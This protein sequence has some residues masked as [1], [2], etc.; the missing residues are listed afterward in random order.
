MMAIHEAP[1]S[2]DEDARG[3]RVDRRAMAATVVAAI[4]LTAVVSYFG[5]KAAR[6]EVRW[7]DVGYTIESPTEA[8]STFDVYLYTDS[9]ATCRV[10]ALNSRFSE[11]GYTDVAVARSAGRQQRMT[12]TVVTV[13][14]AVTAV[15][16]YCQST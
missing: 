9:D 7:G 4:V 14:P 1:E 8:T 3:R 12:A 13:E 10:R 15:V 6:Q 5:L 11:V 16:A 2:A